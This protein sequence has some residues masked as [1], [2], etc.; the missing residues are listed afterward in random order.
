VPAPFATLVKQLGVAPIPERSERE[1]EAYARGVTGALIER[2][3]L[4]RKA[5]LLGQLQRADPGN[6]DAYSQ[7]Q[8]ELVQVEAE[9]RQLRE[10]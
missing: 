4:R 10:G 3:L 1:L 2:D 5:E 8:R 6:R 7:L 9:R